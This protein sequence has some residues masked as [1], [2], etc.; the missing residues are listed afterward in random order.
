MR[1]SLRAD[2]LKTGGEGRRKQRKQRR[3]IILTSTRLSPLNRNMNLPPQNMETVAVSGCQKDL[4][5]RRRQHTTVSL[6]A[7]RSGEGWWQPGWEGG[8]LPET[9]GRDQIICLQTDVHEESASGKQLKQR[10]IVR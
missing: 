8:W 7:R 4:W 1:G 9:N 2:P 6:S 3:I 5:L 10:C